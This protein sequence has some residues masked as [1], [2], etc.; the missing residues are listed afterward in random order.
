MKGYS[1]VMGYIRKREREI[2]SGGCVLEC[3]LI[4]NINGRR[5]ITYGPFDFWTA[6]NISS[7]RINARHLAYTGGMH[8]RKW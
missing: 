7:S 8:L 3:I 2:E 1:H 4:D 6:V 5:I